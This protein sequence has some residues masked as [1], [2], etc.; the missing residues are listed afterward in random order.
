MSKKI[1]IAYASKTGSTA[2][3]AAHVAAVLKKQGWKAAVKNVAEKPDIT[4]YDAVVLG[5]AIHAGQLH[6]DVNA[7]MKR[8]KDAL[9]QMPVAYFVACLGM[10]D[11]T[12]ESWK[13]VESYLDPLYE[14]YPEVKPVAQGQFAGA[15]ELKKLSWIFRTMMKLMKAEEGDFRDSGAI[16][17]WAKELAGKLG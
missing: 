5:S 13:Q 7:F 8:H 10:K 1:L 9:S 2:E 12:P 17:G 6:G 4:E 16:R 3:I 14:K 11:A 15:L